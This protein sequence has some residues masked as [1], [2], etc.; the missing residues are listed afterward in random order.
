[1]ASP[2]YIQLMK[3][4][5][6][7]KEKI[8]EH[9]PKT[10]D[11]SLEEF[12]VAKYIYRRQRHKYDEE[13]LNDD[14]F[15]GKVFFE[16]YKAREETK[17]LIGY[18]ETLLPDEEEILNYVLAQIIK[19][20]IDEMYQNPEKIKNFMIYPALLNLRLQLLYYNYGSDGQYFFQKI[21]K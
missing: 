20:V 10:E 19:E 5:L 15:A 12:L 1:M 14:I 6:E 8:Q 17:D 4:H 7:L 3:Y 16:C 11:I 2:A 9:Y 21:I 18:I 13:V